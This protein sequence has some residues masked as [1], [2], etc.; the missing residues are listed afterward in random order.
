MLY[1]LRLLRDTVLRQHELPGRRRAGKMGIFAMMIPI[2]FVD[3]W[4]GWVYMGIFLI[5]CCSF[6]FESYKEMA[7]PGEYYRSGKRTVVLAIWLRERYP[8]ETIKALHIY[9]KQRHHSLSSSNKV[10]A[11]A[12]TFVTGIITWIYTKIE[13][14]F[15]DAE[16]LVPL[17][18]L[19]SVVFLV[20]DG[21][22]TTIYN[23]IELAHLLQ[24]DELGE[25]AK[26]GFQAMD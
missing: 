6:A 15:F 1:W 12:M 18:G 16:L 4:Y 22:K 5:V 3:P 20:A 14:E 25:L 26:I 13:Y 2:P 9:S 23:A 8:P 7:D 19:M 17:A 21:A 10:A 11:L 24:P